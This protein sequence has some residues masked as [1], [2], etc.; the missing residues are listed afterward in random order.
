VNI[1]RIVLLQLKEPLI[2]AHVQRLS[3]QAAQKTAP[4]QRLR[5]RGAEKDG[6]FQEAADLWQRVRDANPDDAQAAYHHA[7]MLMAAGDLK[8]AGRA[9]MR[10]SELAPEHVETRELLITFFD[11]MGMKLNARRERDTVQ[12]ML[13]ARALQKAKE[14]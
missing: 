13:E 3:H 2:E 14:K 11:R 9:A 12:R 10:A 1:L 4:A 6:N 5:A 8:S 7:R